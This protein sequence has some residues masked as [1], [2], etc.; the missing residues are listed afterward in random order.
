MILL[1]NF[2]LIEGLGDQA[3]TRT[4][5]AAVGEVPPEEFERK[6]RAANRADAAQVC[7]VINPLACRFGEAEVVGLFQG[8]RLFL[9]QR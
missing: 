8:G 4:H 7:E 6:S 1:D 3:G 9:D 2:L 5:L